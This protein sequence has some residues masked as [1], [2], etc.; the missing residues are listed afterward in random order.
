MITT[1]TL[2]DFDRANE[3]PLSQGGN[4]SATRTGNGAVNFNSYGFAST[5]RLDS[6]AAKENSRASASH[7]VV[8][9]F[10]A[11]DAEVWG[12]CVGTAIGAGFEGMGLCIHLADADTTGV[13]GYVAE[14]VNEIFFSGWRL[15]KLA[16][17]VESTLATSG[18]NG[19]FTSDQA[20]LRRVGSDLE[21]WVNKVNGVHSPNFGWLNVITFSDTSYE[22]GFPGLFVG[23]DDLHWGEFGGGGTVEYVP[24]IL[25]Y[26]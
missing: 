8:G 5:C 24:Q 6:N 19:L 15:Y 14:C 26:R 10:P 1:A 4:W 3:N 23:T 17:G 25:R 2:D 12:T 21:I 11:G 9:E 13:D 18:G 16:N 7:R 22:G 20:L